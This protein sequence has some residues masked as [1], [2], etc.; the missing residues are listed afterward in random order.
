MTQALPADWLQRLRATLGRPPAR[1]RVP[2]CWGGEAIGSVEP[3]LVAQLHAERPDARALLVQDASSGSFEVRGDELTGSLGEL[4]QMLHGLGLCHA[5]RDEQLPVTSQDGRELGSVERGV[6]RQLG[7]A[8][9]AVHLMGVTPDGRHWVQQRAFDKPNDPGLWDTL[10]GG[11]VPVGEGLQEALAR[12]TCEEAGL[13]LEQLRVEY[14]GSLLSQGPAPDSPAGY[15]V[16]RIHWYRCVVPEGVVPRN[17]DGEVER[18]EVLTSAE[19]C[20]R[21][22]AGG[23]TIEA[24]AVFA[25][26]LTAQRV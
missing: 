22:V 14:G 11:L 13:A 7:V 9:L 16:E 25:A 15:V 8:T 3:Q 17:L 24:A 19:L 4:A 2:L 12:E 21:L 20:E 5:W 6:V 23:F 10:M 1:P 26:A 18:F